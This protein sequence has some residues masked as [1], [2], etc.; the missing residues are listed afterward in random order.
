[1]FPNLPPGFSPQTSGLGRFEALMDRPVAQVISHFAS[2]PEEA[3]V[4]LGQS[5]EKRSSPSTFVAEVGAKFQVGW[6]DGERQ[7]VQV[8]DSLAEAVTDYLLLSFG[9]G[10]L[11]TERPAARDRYAGKPLLILLENYVL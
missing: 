6:F 8:F 2:H 7:A 10:R 11:V 5:Y 1:M 4:V 9:K 3:G